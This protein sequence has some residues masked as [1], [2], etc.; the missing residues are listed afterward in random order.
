MIFITDHE[1]ILAFMILPLLLG[2]KSLGS[3]NS[4]VKQLWKPSLNET[5]DAFILHCEVLD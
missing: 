2:N 3:T 5:S 4:K 1:Q